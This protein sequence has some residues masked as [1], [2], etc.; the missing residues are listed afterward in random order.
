MREFLHLLMAAV[1]RNNSFFCGREDSRVPMH[2]L[3]E[4]EKQTFYYIGRVIALTLVYGGPAPCFF[5]PAVADY[6][7]YGI[8]KVKVTVDDVPNK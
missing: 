1:A 4:L 3:P 5:S 2:S 7:V 8:Q 6:I